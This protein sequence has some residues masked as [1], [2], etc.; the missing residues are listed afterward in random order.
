MFV[1]GES[2]RSACSPFYFLFDLSVTHQIL[3][4]AQTI[5]VNP[6]AV[7]HYSDPLQTQYNCKSDDEELGVGEEKGT[8]TL[9]GRKWLVRF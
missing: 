8:S 6:T 3:D 1:V 7:S 5:D 9:K 2:E 4:C